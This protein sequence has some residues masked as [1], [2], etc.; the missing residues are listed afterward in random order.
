MQNITITVSEAGTAAART[1]AYKIQIDGI[2]LVRENAYTSS[3]STGTGDCISVLLSSAERGLCQC[4]R[5]S[6][7]PS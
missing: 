5:L 3:D 2:V 1:F 6:A 4:K 7:H